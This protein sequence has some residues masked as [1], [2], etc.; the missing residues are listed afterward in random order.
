PLPEMS[1]PDPISVCIDAD[2]FALSGATPQGGTYTGTGVAAGM[3]DP[4]VAGAGTHSITYT[5]VNPETECENYCMFDI[6]VNELPTVTVTGGEVCPDQEIWV[7]ADP[8]PADDDNVDYEYSWSYNGPFPLDFVDPGNVASFQTGIVGEYTVVITN[9]ETEC[10]ATNS[11]NVTLGFIQTNAQ[12]TGI[13]LCISELVE[14]GDNFIKSRT[15]D[16]G[17]DLFVVFTKL[18]QT[19]DGVVTEIDLAETELPDNIIDLISPGTYEFFIKLKNLQG[20]VSAN[21]QTFSIVV[22]DEPTCS[23]VPQDTICVGDEFSLVYDGGGE[24]L[25]FFWSSDGDAIIADPYAMSTTATNVVDGEIFTLQ[26]ANDNECLSTCTIE[27]DVKP[28]VG[29]CGTAY[30]KLADDASI[31]NHTDTNGAI[32]F[33]EAGG[34]ARWGWTNKL[35]CEGNYEMPIYRGA[36]QCDISKGELVGTAMVSYIDGGVT[37]NL[38][39]DDNKVLSEAHVYVGCDPFPSKK[40]GGYYTVAPGQYPFNPSLSCDGSDTYVQNYTVTVNAGELDMD[41]NGG[42][43]VIIHTVV[44]DLLCDDNEGGCTEEQLAQIISE[45]CEGGTQAFTTY[46]VDCYLEKDDDDGDGVV[47]ACDA[48]MKVYGEGPDGCPLEAKSVTS[49]ETVNFVAYP[50]PFKN[51][52]NLQYRFEYD[53]QVDFEV[54]DTKGALIRKAEDNNYIK[55]SVGTKSI[56]LSAADSQLFFVR[57]STNRGSLV[58][59]IVSDK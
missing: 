14:Q 33:E 53:T 12:A 58:K 32:C 28:C 45:D 15:V 5:Y 6:T 22:F 2:A 50:V 23:I 4:A 7:T 38:S 59:K 1:C 29:N 36:G 8:T 16:P 3:F 13:D 35:N 46:D 25:E 34:F 54:F 55:G 27:A 19:I 21:P 56:D 26:L 42:I 31:E 48:C 47:D 44:C 39:V 18:I 20:C 10:T 51:I 40:K 17:G 49:T 9:T 52:I 41:F 11:G 37:V 30:A 24:G 43:F 57:L